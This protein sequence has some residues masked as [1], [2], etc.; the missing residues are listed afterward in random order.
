MNKLTI[1][2]ENEDWYK[3]LIG[4]CQAI[5]TEGIWNYRWTLIKTYHLFGKRII[6]DYSKFKDV[7][8]SEKEIRSHVTKDLKQS[9][10]T[11]RRTIQFAKKYPDLEKLPE[12]KNISWHKICNELLP[13]QNE[14]EEKHYITCIIDHEEKTIW[15][16]GKY[17]DYEIKFKL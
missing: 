10:R 3:E 13:G 12:G 1:N 17:K 16:N 15:I 5:L 2:L 6:E 14:K 8:I 4:D 9:D 7:G 11:I